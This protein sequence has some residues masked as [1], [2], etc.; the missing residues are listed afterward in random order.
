LT[1]TSLD[2]GRKRFGN[3]SR[4]PK[5]RRLSRKRLIQPLFDRDDVD[6]CSISSGSVRILYRWSG[7]EAGQTRVPFQVGFAVGRSMGK[8]VARN[9]IKR[10]LR[11]EV[12]RNLGVLWPA[13]EDVRDML[14]FMVVVRRRPENASRLRR[15]VAAGLARLS[16]AIEADAGERRLFE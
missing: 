16:E 1:A 3:S 4:L 9:R 11:D 8:A 13:L 12:R 2:A 10:V 6:T 5:S 15:D 14:T 7:Q